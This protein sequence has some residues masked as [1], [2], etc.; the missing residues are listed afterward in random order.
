MTRT[1][2]ARL[3][4]YMS[5]AGREREDIELSAAISWSLEVILFYGVTGELPSRAQLG[6][7][8]ANILVG[9][10]PARP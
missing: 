8:I 3:A 2:A 10:V 4:H 5:G 1:E 7:V 9:P 6:A